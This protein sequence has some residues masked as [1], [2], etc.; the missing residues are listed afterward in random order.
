MRTKNIKKK[1]L[2]LVR[3]KFS[4]AQSRFQTNN[5]NAFQVFML[6]EFFEQIFRNIVIS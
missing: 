5:V 2:Q 4:F 3:A 6:Q 1:N